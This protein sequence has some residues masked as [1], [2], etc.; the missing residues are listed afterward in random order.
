M[1]DICIG[2]SLLEMTYYGRKKFCLGGIE[3]HFYIL[4]AIAIHYEQTRP[5]FMLYKIGLYLYVFDSIE[6][7]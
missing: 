7:H 4:I 2:P 3:L 6:F 1:E 5:V